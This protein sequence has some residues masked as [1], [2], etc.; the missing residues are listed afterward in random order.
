MSK[1]VNIRKN[2]FQVYGINNCLPILNSSNYNVIDIF[3]AQESN[4]DF[5]KLL[6]HEK[7]GEN[8]QYLKKHNFYDKFGNI[9]A[10]EKSF[11]TK[12]QFLGEIWKYS[13]I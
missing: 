3:I 2:V 11:F 6:S 10:D 1:K 9:A 5:K 4:T 12:K 13:R 8:I 7:Y